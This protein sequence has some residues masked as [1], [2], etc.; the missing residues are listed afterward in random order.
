MKRTLCALL[1]C[2]PVAAFAYPIEVEKRYNGSEIT[3]TTDD[4]DHNMGSINVYNL[5][6]ARAE[7][8]VRFTNGPETPKIRRAVIEG[9][10][11]VYLTAKF[12]R[13][14]I[15]LRIGLTCKPA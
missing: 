8:T 15:R 13:S 4:I 1:A 6:E 3:Y 10:K 11:S 2:L 9:G 14:I 12:N 5:G 7:C